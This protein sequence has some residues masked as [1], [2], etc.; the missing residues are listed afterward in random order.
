MGDHP[1]DNR[2]QKKEKDQ[3]AKEVEDRRSISTREERGSKNDPPCREIPR[4]K[5]EE[6][7]FEV[8]AE[9]SR[10]DPARPY[11]RQRQRNRDE[12]INSE[13]ESFRTIMNAFGIPQDL[14]RRFPYAVRY[15]P[16]MFPGSRIT[17]DETKDRRHSRRM[18]ESENDGGKIGAKRR[19]PN[20]RAGGDDV[21][22]ASFDLGPGDQRKERREQIGVL[23]PRR[24]K[25]DQSVSHILPKTSLENTCQ[26]PRLCA[27]L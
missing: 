24:E 15:D 17:F 2:H 12:S 22:D 26:S 8:E 18:Q 25:V 7:V 19:K 10:Q 27:I 20:V 13:K 4:R 3:H 9:H 6:G 21:E 5:S 14:F 16:Q 11:T 1:F 23:N